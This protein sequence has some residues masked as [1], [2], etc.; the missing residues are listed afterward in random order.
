[1]LTVRAAFQGESEKGHMVYEREGLDA[2]LAYHSLTEDRDLEIGPGLD[3]LI[4]GKENGDLEK[5]GWKPGQPI[6]VMLV[7]RHSAITAPQVMRSLEK[8]GVEVSQIVLT[9]GDDVFPYVD[10]LSPDLVLTANG[11]TADEAVRHGHRAVLM[12]PRREPYPDDVTMARVRRIVNRKKSELL[13]P[14]EKIRITVATAALFDQE[15][16]SQCFRDGGVEAYGEWMKSR[17]EPLAPGAAFPMVSKMVEINNLCRQS[18]IPEPFEICLI[19]RNSVETARPILESLKHYGMSGMG[20]VWTAGQDTLPHIVAQAPDLS[21]LINQETSRRLIQHGI[22]S[23]ALVPM[24]T[25]HLLE[26][27][28]KLWVWL[29]GDAVLFDG[30]SERAYMASGLDG[31]QEFERQN[32]DRPMAGGSMM[33]LTV[34]LVRWRDYLRANPDGPGD[35]IGIG[36][37]TARGKSAYH[38]PLVTLREWEISLDKVIFNNGM[39]KGAIIGPCCI[40]LDDGIMHVMRVS[41]KGSLEGYPAAV[42]LDGPRHET[43]PDGQLPDPVNFTGGEVRLVAV[44]PNRP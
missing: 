44:K 23:A 28:E 37:L 15:E 5:L 35:V 36:M 11:E 38:R 4:N 14:P 3:L 43:G 21:L 31:F 34:K 18:G 30:E 19:S 29:D 40:F 2:F 17:K 13:D 42:V 33:A 25:E 24:P 39:D 32:K 10:R 7:S 26:K 9:S 8:A 20:T 22:P 16:A 27:L 41:K 6:Y 12:K 1:M